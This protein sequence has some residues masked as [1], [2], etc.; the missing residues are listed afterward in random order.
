MTNI[1]LTNQ[2]RSS[3]MTRLLLPHDTWTLQQDS[4]SRLR[5]PLRTAQVTTTIYHYIIT[6]ACAIIVGNRAGKRVV[7]NSNAAMHQL[8]QVRRSLHRTLRE[9]RVLCVTNEGGVK[10]AALV[11]PCI[12]LGGVTLRSV[13]ALK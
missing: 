8:F 1:K 3:E 5:T 9:H 12:G 10:T 11:K 4:S 2:P 7:Y 13:H 6:Q